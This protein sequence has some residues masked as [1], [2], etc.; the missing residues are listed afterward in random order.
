MS[1]AE[2]GRLLAFA[3]CSP[4]VAAAGC[5]NPCGIDARLV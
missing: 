1:E 3:T 2:K 5:A 4:C